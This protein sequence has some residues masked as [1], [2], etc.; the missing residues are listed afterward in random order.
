[1]S[2]GGSANFSLGLTEEGVA[3]SWGIN[4]AGNLGVGDV[5]PRSS[6]VAVLGSLNVSQYGSAIGGNYATSFLIT[7]SNKLY[8]WGE[9]S[10]GMLGLGDIVPI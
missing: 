5:I 4:I 8:T 1:M 9:N 2:G 3:Y 7:T 10:L 6:P